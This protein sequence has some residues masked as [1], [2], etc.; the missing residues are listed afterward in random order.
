VVDVRFRSGTIEVEGL[1]ADFAG[2]PAEWDP[3]SA[4]H[5]APALSYPEVLRALTRLQIS[6]QDHARR[7]QVLEEGAR[8][9]HVTA[10]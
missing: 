2:L 3:R 1:G 4:C 9:R 10:P 5:R 7:Y 6:Y 8:A